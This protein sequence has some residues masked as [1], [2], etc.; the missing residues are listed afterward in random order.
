MQ[1]YNM[2]KMALSQN[3]MPFFYNNKTLYHFSISRM[4]ENAKCW[5]D[6][7]PVKCMDVNFVHLLQ[8]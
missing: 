1:K 5:T 6:F 8:G 2:G 7:E 3:S 4:Q